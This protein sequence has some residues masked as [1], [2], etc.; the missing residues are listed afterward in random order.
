MR[1]VFRLVAVACLATGC[2]TA[3]S[4]FVA[5]SPAGPSERLPIEGWAGFTLGSSYTEVKD[6]LNAEGY[7]VA[8]AGRIDP[9]K[10]AP[11][12]VAFLLPTTADNTRALIL[13][14]YRAD[15]L[16]PGAFYV[17]LD[18]SGDGTLVG[19]GLYYRDAGNFDARRY[20]RET[21]VPQLNG[22]YQRAVGMVERGREVMARWSDS[23]SGNEAILAGIL[24]SSGDSVMLAYLKS[25][26]AE[27]SGERF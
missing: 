26:Y 21:I 12:K 16:P 13:S 2:V 18:F 7:H 6:R 14:G 27:M 24:S 8:E 25:G 23:V 22:R 15:N 3:P 19:I 5:E 20:A 4:S 10:V 11:V 9:F 17:A 1:S